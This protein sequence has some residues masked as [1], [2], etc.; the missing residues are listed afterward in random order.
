MNLSP[1]VIAHATDSDLRRYD[2]VL[3]DFAYWSAR[4]VSSLPATDD[5]DVSAERLATR[6]LLPLMKQNSYTKKYGRSENDFNYLEEKIDSVARL[7]SYTSLLEHVVKHFQ[8]HAKPIRRYDIEEDDAL[9]F[10]LSEPVEVVCMS[11]CLK[12][13]KGT[14]FWD[15]HASLF[16][17]R[18][19]EVKG[20]FRIVSVRPTF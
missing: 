7:Q 13:P 14:V 5:G 9:D 12:Y 3:M 17:L 15:I 8:S 11:D 4:W 6:Q 20:K 16:R 1:E 18:V 19:A 10:S 2:A